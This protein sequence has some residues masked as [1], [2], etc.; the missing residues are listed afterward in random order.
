[1]L[2]ALQNLWLSTC[3]AVST[4]YGNVTVWGGSVLTNIG[5][6]IQAAGTKILGG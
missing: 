2:L 1:M 4:G 6:G 3:T 5:T